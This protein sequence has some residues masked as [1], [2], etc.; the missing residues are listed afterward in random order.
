MNIAQICFGHVRHE[1]LKPKHHYFKYKVFSLLIPMKLR[2]QYSDGI[3]SFGLGDNCFSW[4]SFYDQ[5]H[6]QGTHNSLEWAMSVVNDAKIQDVDGEVWLQTFPRVLGYVFNPVSFW[7]FTNRTG[8]LRAVIA[9]VNNTF[10][11]R[12]CYLLH[13]PDGRDIKGGESLTA[14]KA[15]HVSPFYTIEGQYIFRFI[16]QTN[17]SRRVARIEYHQQGPSLITSINGQAEPYSMKNFFKVLLQYPLMTFG[18]ITKIHW[19]ALQLWLKGIPF[20][21]SPKHSELKI[22]K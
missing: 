15:F 12:H 7:F 18:V 4:L 2:H 8:G 17:S 22:S 21:S 11:D 3:R 19:Q 20:H 6:G 5:D 9:E 1:R 14:T 13:H 10:G 16:E